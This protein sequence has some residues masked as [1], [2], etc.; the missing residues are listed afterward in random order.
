M[1]FRELLTS[2]GTSTMAMVNV[3][4]PA[5]VE[6]AAYAGFDAVMIDAEHGA[7]DARDVQELVR[8]ADAARIPTLVR[9]PRAT[10]EF[11][12]RALDCGAGGILAPQVATGADAADAVAECRYPPGGR[13]GAAFYTR[14][15]RFTFDRGRAAIAA[16]DEATVVGVQVESVDAVAAATEIFATPGLD[17]GFV[18][19]TDLSVDHGS[20][21]PAHP[22]MVDAI[23]GVAA[24]GRDAGLPMAIYAT[25]PDAARR[26]AELG[27]RIVAVGVMALVARAVA[28]YVD[29]VRA[30]APQSLTAEES[31]AQ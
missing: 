11:V 9:P 1:S 3:P 28:G 19:P 29:G 14:G 26:Y 24:A 18:G 30:A 15:Q 17:F 5:L 27:Y 10:K 21:D 31:Q 12:L 4:E 16:A 7:L 8:A 25:D 13:R 22:W 6:V 23:A 20:C 2:P